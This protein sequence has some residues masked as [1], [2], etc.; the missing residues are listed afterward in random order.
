MSLIDLIKDNDG[1]RVGVCIATISIVGYLM[2]SDMKSKEYKLLP[3][4]EGMKNTREMLRSDTLQSKYNMS[5]RFERGVV[6]K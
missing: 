4:N 5:G 3:F 6:Y 2:Y 1:F